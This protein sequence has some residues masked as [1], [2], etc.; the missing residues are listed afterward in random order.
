MNWNSKKITTLKNYCFKKKLPLY[1]N[2]RF[3]E[4]YRFIKNYHFNKITPS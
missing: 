3:I 2:Y 1:K 4:N